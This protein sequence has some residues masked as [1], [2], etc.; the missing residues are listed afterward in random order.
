MPKNTVMQQ[1]EDSKNNILQKLQNRINKRLEK[2]RDN[3]LNEDLKD[4]EK[5]KINR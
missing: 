3:Y 5:K 1:E 2:M 4:K